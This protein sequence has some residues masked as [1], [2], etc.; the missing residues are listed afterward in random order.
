[1]AFTKIIQL[2]DLHLTGTG[3]ALFGA[4]P[5]ERL[6]AAIDLI[7]RDHRDAALCLLTGDLAEAGDDAA[8]AELARLT[9]RLGMPVHPMVGNHDD[10]AALLR[11]F[12]AAG[13]GSGFVQRALDTPAGHLLL[14]DTLDPGRGSGL[15]C[16]ERLAWLKSQ[17]WRHATPTLLAMHH[18]P[19]AVGIPAMDQYAL[20]NPEEFWAV[21]APHR[22]RIRH[23]LLGHLH[24]PLGGNWRGISISCT[25]SPNHQ[26]ALDLAALP[27]DG[28]VPGCQ[29]PASFSVILIDD[30]SVVV[31]HQAM[32][33]GGKRFPL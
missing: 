26:V 19:L 2:S 7:Q 17:S 32:A 9:S 8:Y 5:G 15:L 21:I 28:A 25:H 31:H 16:A 1:M 22:H 23:I 20:R 14:L 30:D 10:R 18:P 6:A 13:D 12:P 3:Q 4:R 33:E 24:R 11:H 29:E 27:P